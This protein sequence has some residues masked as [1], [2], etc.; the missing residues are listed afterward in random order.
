LEPISGYL[1]LAETLVSAGP[2][3]AAAWNFGPDEAS[4]KTVGWVA[5]YL[6]QKADGA[7]WRK[8][9]QE[10][11]HETEILSLDS[12]KAASKLG[13]RP[14]WSIES[15]LDATIAWHEAQQELRCMDD[16]SL[17]QISLFESA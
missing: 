4:L 16:Y 3:V 8:D 12:D 10:Y 1:L 9:K 2:E 11:P 7:S 14:R 13:W 6:S 15:A 5:D 17:N